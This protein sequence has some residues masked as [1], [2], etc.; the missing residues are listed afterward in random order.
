MV[1]ANDL[2]YDNSAQ[3]L[4][5]QAKRN[6]YSKRQLAQSA[7]ADLRREKFQDNF[8]R[9]KKPFTKSPQFR[10][11]LQESY[12]KTLNKKVTS[13]E[14]A[15]RLNKPKYLKGT[16]RLSTSGVVSKLAAAALPVAGVA[17]GGRGR[18]RPNASFTPKVLPNGQVVNMPV[19]AF[20]RAVTAMKAQMRLQRE[21]ARQKMAGYQ[22]SAQEMPSGYGQYDAEDAYMDQAQMPVYPQQMQQSVPQQQFQGQPQ[23]SRFSG[24]GQRFMQAVMGRQEPAPPM[25]AGT[26]AAPRLKIWGEGVQVPRENNILNAPNIFN[27]PGDTTIGVGR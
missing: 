22:P 21:L 3:E 16:G 10:Q 12:Q 4:V 2:V 19:Q 5:A 20:K 25:S 6:D 1:S 8:N 9:F 7:R 15:K 14:T 26:F 23:P 18:G 24:M 13:Y 17:S 11:K 27:R